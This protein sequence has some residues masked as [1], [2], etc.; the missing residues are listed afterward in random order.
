[1]D[2]NWNTWKQIVQKTWQKAVDRKYIYNNIVIYIIL[3]MRAWCARADRYMRAW[4]AR[5][6]RGRVGAVF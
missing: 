5:D 6:A 2:T 1:M 3:R 4:G